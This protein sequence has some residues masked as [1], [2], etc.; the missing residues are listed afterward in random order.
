WEPVAE[1]AGEVVG[2]VALGPARDADIAPEGGGPSGSRLP[3]GEL[4]ALY[5]EPGLIGT[6]VG[7]ELLA[8]G[9]DR[10]RASGFGTLCLWVVRGDLRARRFYE[11]AGFVPDGAAEA[12]EVGGRSV[13]ELRYRRPPPSP[14]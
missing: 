4:P 2:W 9:T 11:R 7:R 14:A 10:A 3:V 8:A 5:V 6:G 12:Y 13:P 1:R